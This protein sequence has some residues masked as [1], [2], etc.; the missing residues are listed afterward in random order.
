MNINHVDHKDDK[1]FGNNYCLAERDAYFH[2]IIILH[3]LSHVPSPHILT[4]RCKPGHVL[5]IK[6]Y[7]EISTNATI[8]FRNKKFSNT[9]ETEML[10]SLQTFFK[11]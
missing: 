10:F 8:L 2:T 6:L 7:T 1:V 9:L 3:S 4:V 5:H 11:V